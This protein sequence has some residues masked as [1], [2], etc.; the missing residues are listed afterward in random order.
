VSRSA[1]LRSAASAASPPPDSWIFPRD[2]ITT[3]WRLGGQSSLLNKV[4]VRQHPNAAAFTELY[5]PALSLCVVLE[6]LA[7]LPIMLGGIQ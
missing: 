6:Q 5:S 2:S 3:A 1:I 7:M 4:S